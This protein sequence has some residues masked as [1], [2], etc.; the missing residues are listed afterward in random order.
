VAY[1][2]IHGIKTTLTK[3]LDYINNPD[4]TDQ[5]LLVSG[6]N[7]DPLA[8]AVE[9]RMTAAL[10]KEA[11]GDY[12]KTGGA[13]NLA[14][15]MIQ[16]FAPYDKITPAEA[17]ELGKKWADE[18]LKGKYEY[19]ISTHVDK[20]QIHNHVIFNA[21]SFYDY[22]K[23]DN[24]KVA[25]YLREVSDKLCEE[26][27]LHVIKNPNLKQKS[28]SHYEWEQRKTNN[29][30][31]AKIKDII[32]KTISETSDYESFKKGLAA[33]NVEVKEGKRISFRLAG[34]E[35]FCRGDRMGEDYTKERI[36]ERLTFQKEE[37]RV[38]T[39]QREMPTFDKDIERKSLQTRLANTK[40]LAAA[41]LTI[42]NEKIERVG[43]FEVRIQELSAKA[44]DVSN[45]TKELE[46]K[47]KQYKD[48]AKY[49]LA[50]RQ[51]ESVKQAAERKSPFGKNKY[52]S[53]HEGE[54]AAYDHAARQLKAM[55]INAN[56]DP[57]KVLAMT[58]DQ[59][60]KIYECKA[61]LKEVSER[62]DA[63]RETQRLADEVQN[64]HERLGPHDRKETKEREEDLR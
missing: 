53:L 7:V 29:S 3:A 24:Y 2:R 10:A 18:V 28:P 22:K 58:H 6:Y 61:N 59:D 52:V 37:T 23:Y 21:V 35:R 62:I 63:L 64:G 49:L 15:H 41:L 46:D 54:I 44:A 20:G 51:Y 42:R 47:N 57:D 11:K 31:K 26:Q 25:G 30:W 17:H 8:A 60:K 12:T 16:S 33:A 50:V 34:K 40:E 39:S 55:G 14:Y 4:K 45:T 48:V 27:G 36:I 32:D 9:Y 1:T 38:S 19:V 56:V 43:D 13:E 5:Q